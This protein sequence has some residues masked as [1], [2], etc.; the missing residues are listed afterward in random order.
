[1]F[2]RSCKPVANLLCKLGTLSRKQKSSL[3]QQGVYSHIGLVQVTG[4]AVCHMLHCV[5]ERRQG[6]TA[7]F[8]LWCCG[9]TIAL[10]SQLSLSRL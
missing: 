9:T 10:A 1:M 8:I 2:T 6:M 7:Y 4:A 5:S 3:V